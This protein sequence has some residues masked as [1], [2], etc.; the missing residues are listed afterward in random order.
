MDIQP[1][2]RPKCPP[3]AQLSL[4]LAG[5]SGLKSV[6]LV[7]LM[8]YDAVLFSTVCSLSTFQFPK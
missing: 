8:I 3:S 5:D 2:I 7:L 6:F 4:V 1:R